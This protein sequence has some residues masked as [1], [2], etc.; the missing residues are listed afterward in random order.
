MKHFSGSMQVTDMAKVTL[1]TGGSDG[2]QGPEGECPG[3][4]LVEY[5]LH[6]LES[7]QKAREA[8]RDRFGLNYLPTLCNEPDPSLWTE[9]VTTIG[10]WFARKDQA[11]RRVTA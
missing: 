2:T 1:Y 7:L 8:V 3:T 10:Q 9:I 4:A 6:D 11:P 5:D